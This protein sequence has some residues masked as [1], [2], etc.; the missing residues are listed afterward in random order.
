MS[1][2]ADIAHD[3]EET[4]ASSEADSEAAVRLP[5]WQIAALVALCLSAVAV[6]L[7]FAWRYRPPLESDFYWYRLAG[8]AA[9]EHGLASLFSANPPVDKWV[10]SIWPPGYPLFLGLL[11]SVQNGLWAAP[12]TQ[13]MLGGVSCFAIFAAARR[14]GGNP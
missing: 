5:G 7:L 1:S 10:L 13:A 6:R 8:L 12:A 2:S 11:Y 3:Q 14:W 4:A 9:A